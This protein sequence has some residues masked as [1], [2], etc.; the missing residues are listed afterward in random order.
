[1]HIRQ[2]TIAVSSKPLSHLMLGISRP[3]LTTPSICIWLSMT[4]KDEL[5]LFVKNT[6]LT[7]MSSQQAILVPGAV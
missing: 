3:S 2:M 6:K 7:R 5:A 4:M 1:M